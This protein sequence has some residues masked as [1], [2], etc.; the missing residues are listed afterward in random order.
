MIKETRFEEE[1]RVSYLDYAMSVIIS[2]ALPDVRDG[3]K[4]V[5]RRI[6]YGMR[7]MG[8]RSNSPYKKSARVVGDVLGKYHP[9]GDAPVYEA[10]VRMAQDF[11]IRYPLIDGQGNFGSIDNDPPAAMRYTEVRLSRL[12]EEMLRDIEKDV[13]DFVPNFDGSTREP[14]VL[15]ARIP[16]LLIN[17]SSGI[18][19]GMA[20]NIPPHN[21]KEVCDALLYLLENPDCGLGELMDFIKGPD[22][23]TGG[24]I[25]GTEGIRN[26]YPTG[27]GKITL[28]AKTEVRDG[29]IIITEFPFQVNKASIVEKIARLSRERRIEGISEIRDE[30]DREGIRVVIEIKKGFDP[31]VVLRNLY[32]HTNL[33]VNFAINMLALVDG[34]PKVLNLKQALL[35]FLN[36]RREVVR[37]RTEFELKEAKE[38]E[39]ILLGFKVVIENIDEVVS[40][41]KGSRDPDTA[42]RNLME[43]FGLTERQAQAILDM[44]LRRLSS[45]ERERVEKEI[46]ELGEKIRT[47]TLILEDP[48]RMDRVIEEEIREIRDKYGDGRRSVISEE[49]P[50][51]FGVEELIPHQRV[52]V[53]LSERDY[54]KRLPVDVFRSQRR[55]GKGVLGATP[56]FIVADTH[57]TILFVTDK[58]RILSLKCYKIPQESSK[59]GRGTPIINLLPVQGERITSMLPIPSFDFKKYL[60]FVTRKGGIKKVPL[61]DFSSGRVMK[62]INLDGDEVVSAFCADDEDIFI[63]S[64]SGKLI[65]FSLKDVRESGRG[66]GAVRG[67]RAEDVKSAGLVREYLLTITS[68]GFG[69]LTPFRDFPLQRRGGVG[70]FSHKILKKTGELVSALGVNRKDEV[71]ILSS[72]S[73]LRTKVS[74]I[75]VQGRMASGVKIMNVEEGDVISAFAF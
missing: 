50:S 29:K 6:L 24:L 40:I 4:P 34:K 73:I 70:I 52:A 27:R 16:N 54:I 26:A 65:K 12:A 67:M 28:R 51:E 20:T 9:H 30:S 69:K 62:A 18:A 59:D 19:V 44:Q 39:H 64:N 21:L 14:V 17:G 32:K 68:K 10:M 61:R 71:F 7:E 15:P 46:G 22:F 3:L 58:G 8:V 47:L 63:A 5:Q 41:I 74:E 48:V 42:K 25:L 36:F 45:I 31:F 13:V 60:V 75:P 23:P 49:E 66:S 43:R 38:R 55:G 72:T 57:D 1:V 2:R 11:A 53:M 33:Q 56:L 37:R 35:E